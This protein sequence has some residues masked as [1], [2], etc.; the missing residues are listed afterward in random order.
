MKARPPTTMAE[1]L[2]VTTAIGPGASGDRDADVL[3]YHRTA[4]EH[5]DSLGRGQ[6]ARGTRVMLWALRGYVVFMAV[7]VAMQVAQAWH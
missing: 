7:V 4:R 5:V 3:A 2:P 1:G 6:L